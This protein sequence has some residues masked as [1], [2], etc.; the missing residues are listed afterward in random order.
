MAGLN[1]LAP[2]SLPNSVVKLLFSTCK[3]N[4]N[5][6]IYLSE[7]LCCKEQCPNLETE[8]KGPTILTKQLYVLEIG[9]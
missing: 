8:V 3:L 5:P 1:L 6:D 4:A 9:K 2:R 7:Q